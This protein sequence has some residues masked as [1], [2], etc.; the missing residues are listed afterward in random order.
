M[1]E[2][3]TSEEDENRKHSLCQFNGTAHNRCSNCPR[4][5]RSH[6]QSRRCPYDVEE[7]EDPDKSLASSSGKVP[8]AESLSALS[9][10]DPNGSETSSATP[11]S[12]ASSS[13]KG[14]EPET[15]LIIHQAQ[16]LTLADRS[17]SGSCSATSGV[18]SHE[19]I[20][21]T[22]M[23]EIY[24]K[25]TLDPDHQHLSVKDYL[26]SKH[27]RPF[28]ES[29]DAYPPH[30]KLRKLMEDSEHE[31]IVDPEPQSMHHPELQRMQKL[32]GPLMQNSD[33]GRA[34]VSTITGSIP[35]FDLDTNVGL[36]PCRYGVDIEEP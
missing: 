18:P 27:P 25:Q 20:V 13:R 32:E 7:L 28:G 1:P 22:R 12:L 16:K 21:N 5:V 3:F 10:A 11:G 35:S 15:D 36:Y 4:A 19:D 8:E 26:T 9:L 34:S 30:K 31:I 17:A 2:P 24:Q 33:A 29:P 6:L 23:Q 14:K